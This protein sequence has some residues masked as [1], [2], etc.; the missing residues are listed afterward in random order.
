MVQYADG[1]RVHRDLHTSGCKIKASK[2]RID[3]DERYRQNE[4]TKCPF[5]QKDDKFIC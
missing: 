5:K 2:R 3:L 1:I 4:S